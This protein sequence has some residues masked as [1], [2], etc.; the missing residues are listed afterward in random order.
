MK[1]ILR[2]NKDSPKLI[3]KGS[4]LYRDLSPN[5]S[6]SKGKRISFNKIDIEATKIIIDKMEAKILEILNNKKNISRDIKKTASPTKARERGNQ[7]SKSHS[8]MLKINKESG[9]II[10][11]IKQKIPIIFVTSMNLRV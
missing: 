4:S 5:L 10:K 6:N 9:L 1:E 11:K 7:K 3:K 8:V 2:V